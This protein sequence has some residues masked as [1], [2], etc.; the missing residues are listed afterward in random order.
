MIVPPTPRLC[1]S[2]ETVSLAPFI[3]VLEL[4]GKV[5]EGLQHRQMETRRI[6]SV[7]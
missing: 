2:V 5:K 4:H 3:S 1:P 7:P 6:I